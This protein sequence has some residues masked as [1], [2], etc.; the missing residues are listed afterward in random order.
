MN[1]AWSMNE[2]RGG[3][4]EPLAIKGLPLVIK[5]F[6]MSTAVVESHV[7][8]TVIAPVGGPLALKGLPLVLKGLESPA[9][10][11]VTA[12]VGG[13]P[14]ALKGLSLPLVL[15]GLES[16]AALTVTAP[17]GGPLA[18]KGIG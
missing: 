14:L 3:I 16:L 7:V 15:K 6:E 17:E 1:G 13:L 9:A 5:G 4:T 8:L 18:L 11:T 10:L 2:T 12:P